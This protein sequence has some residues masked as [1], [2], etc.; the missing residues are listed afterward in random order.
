MLL[1]HDYFHHDI[2]H[3]IS[4]HHDSPWLTHQSIYSWLTNYGFWS[5]SSCLAH[6]YHRFIHWSMVQQWSATGHQAVLAEMQQVNVARRDSDV[7]CTLEDVGTTR[8]VGSDWL[9][10]TVGNISTVDTIGNISTIIIYW[11]IFYH[12]SQLFVLGNLPSWGPPVPTVNWH[13]YEV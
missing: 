13:V 8:K 12:R 11:L 6:D 2:Y 5:W 10:P 7:I 4:Y 9:I 1:T 3:D